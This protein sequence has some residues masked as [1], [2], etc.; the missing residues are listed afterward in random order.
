M[1][2]KTKKEKIFEK[3][4]QNKQ[5]D[6]QH[7]YIGHLEYLEVLAHLDLENWLDYTII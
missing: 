5:N 3:L 4:L 2:K 1:K 7:F 6:K